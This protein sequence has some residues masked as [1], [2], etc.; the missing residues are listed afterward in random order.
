MIVPTTPIHFVLRTK[1]DNWSKMDCSYSTFPFFAISYLKYLKL[2]SYPYPCLLFLSVAHLRK[3]HQQSPKFSCLWVTLGSLFY[4]YPIYQPSVGTAGPSLIWQLLIQHLSPFSTVRPVP[5]TTFSPCSLLKVNFLIFLFSP[6]HG[7][8][9]IVHL[10]KQSE[11]PFLISYWKHPIPL[12]P[13]SQLSSDFSE[14]PGST[15]PVQLLFS[16]LQLCWSSWCFSTTT[17][18]FP[19]R[20]FSLFVSFFLQQLCPRSSPNP[21]FSFCKCLLKR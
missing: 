5:A 2:R 19:F 16:L 7:S 3:W 21:Q 4:L 12:L 14:P 6:F 20:G 10:S 18:L 1:T 11:C 8:F 17:R 15:T 13:S 9:T